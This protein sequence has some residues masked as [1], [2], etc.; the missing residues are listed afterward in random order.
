MSE[1]RF[2]R[3]ETRL[4]GIETRLDG[5]ETRLDRLEHGQEVMRSEIGEL[6]IGQ[7]NLIAGQK[8]LR[9]GQKELR[10]GQESLRQDLY[11]HMGVLLEEIVDRIRALAF[12]PASMTRQFQA[13]DNA[14]REEFS[15]RLDP[16]EAALR[17]RRKR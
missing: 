6:R 17:R 14:L 4:D 16:I 1:E 13:A 10:T 15:R 2:D 3:I 8:E 12:D 9:T 5:F 7:E 11:R